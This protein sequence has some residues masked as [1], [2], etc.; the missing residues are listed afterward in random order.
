MEEKNHVVRQSGPRNVK[1]RRRKCIVHRHGITKDDQRLTGWFPKY[2]D[3]LIKCGNCASEFNSRENKGLLVTRR[4]PECSRFALMFHQDRYSSKKLAEQRQKDIQR[5]Q[6]I[7]YNKGCR[8]QF[9][10]CPESG[11][12]ECCYGCPYGM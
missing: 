6:R 1:R 8:R 3:F 5:I 9:P 2:R 10:E 11:V 12:G 4:C 7:I